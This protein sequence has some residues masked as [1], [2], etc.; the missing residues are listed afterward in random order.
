[1]TYMLCTYRNNKKIACTVKKIFFYSLH[2]LQ[3]KLSLFSLSCTWYLFKQ[4]K[5]LICISSSIFKYLIALLKHTS[6][7]IP[8][9]IRFDFAC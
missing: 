6:F 5:V 9:S 8:D 7:F 1:M 4:P 3:R 2:R